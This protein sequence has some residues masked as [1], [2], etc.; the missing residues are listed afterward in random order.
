MGKESKKEWINVYVW[1]VHFVVHLEL[2]QHC[3]STIL[4]W[5]FKNKMKKKYGLQLRSSPEVAYNFLPSKFYK[6]ISQKYNNFQRNTRKSDPQGQDVY[7]FAWHPN[8]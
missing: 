2:T 1:M 6:S 8:H 7:I 3:K 4:Q 5:N